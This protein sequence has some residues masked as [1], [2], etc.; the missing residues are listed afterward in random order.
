MVFNTIPFMDNYKISK[1][2]I[3]CN[4]SGVIIKPTS[5]DT[6][7]IILDGKS[8]SIIELLRLTFIS[9]HPIKYEYSAD[10]HSICDVKFI[11]PQ[12]KINKINDM[13]LNINECLYKQIREYPGYYISNDGTVYSSKTNIL[14]LK[15]YNIDYPVVA[16]SIENRK[17]KIE[18][19]HRLVYSTWADIDLKDL[20]VV[21]HRDNRKYNSAFYNLER[22]TVFHN[23]RYAILDGKKYSRYTLNQID[24]FCQLYL[25]GY[26]FR[27]ISS[28]IFGNDGEYSNIRSIIYR[29]KIGSAYSDIANKYNLSSINIPNK[30]KLA[31][32]DVICI[33]KLIK[34]G[35]S[36]NSIAKKYNV[37]WPT[38][39]SIKTGKHW[40]NV[41]N[42]IPPIN[43][44]D[45]G[46]TTIESIS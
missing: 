13:Y 44:K 9:F 24:L 29:M 32:N 27:D 23:T 21:H 3:I 19:I 7:I 22:S 16:F 40:K 8:F 43:K 12:L 6:S 17:S 34:C 28:C 5:N 14:M 37:S 41:Q 25:D 36:I 11:I 31:D 46:S 39:N 15:K 45:E 35:E 38:I 42:N 1:N 2:G 33:R 20:E 18:K 10:K 26:S 4:D 30:N